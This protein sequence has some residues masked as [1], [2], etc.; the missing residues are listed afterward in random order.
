MALRGIEFH[1]EESPVAITKAADGSLS[2]K[3]SKGTV[4]GFSHIMFATGRKPNTKV[5]SFDYVVL[6]FV[7][8]C[9]KTKQV[10][11]NNILAYEIIWREDFYLCLPIITFN[12][13]VIEKDMTKRI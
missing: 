6:L 1:T 7:V 4:D 12:Q 11:A 13:K 2:L 8:D 9:L 5:W 3:T 10:P